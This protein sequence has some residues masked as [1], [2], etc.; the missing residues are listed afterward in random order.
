MKLVTAP[1]DYAQWP[2][3]VQ[4]LFSSQLPPERVSWED[5]CQLSLLSAGQASE[6][7]PSANAT[8]GAPSFS[9][10][11]PRRYWALAKLAFYHQSPSRLPLLYRLAWRLRND[12]SLLS[13]PLDSDVRDLGKLVKEVQRDAHK[14]RA[15]IRFREL[16]AAPNV[17]K[18]VAWHVPMHRVLRLVAPFFVDRMPHDVWS[19]LT[20]FESAHWDLRKLSYGGPGDGRQA[21]AFDAQEELWRSYYKSIFNPARVNTEAMLTEMPKKYWATMPETQDIAGMLREARGREQQM[22]QKVELKAGAKPWVPEERDLL[23]LRSAA[24]G[25][26]GCELYAAAT[27]TVFGEGPEDAKLM[28][29]G[30]QPGDQEDR[31]GRPFVGPAGQLLDRALVA[32]ELPRE[33]LYVT[34]AVKHFAFTPRGKRRLHRKP[35]AGEVKACKPWLHAEMERVKPQ[36]VV[37]LGA[38]AAQ[39]LF[40]SSFR[41]T[42]Q[43][44]AWLETALAPS[45]LATWHPSNLLRMDDPERRAQAWEEL[46]GD[47]RRA[48]SCAA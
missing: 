38:T 36:T 29:I 8:A 9:A 20:P 24:Q 37:C 42:Q 22:I 43:R 12:I 40:G 4:R 32:A 13:D 31:Q 25:C 46:V 11:L 14:A 6:Q 17:P 48:G 23:S 30:E 47:L 1:P 3:Q 34:N 21:P 45:C 39:T 7:V 33:Q 35:R 26:Q 10:K 44:G 16:E 2:E 5:A 28:L 41:L 27:Q 15:F 19:I 18:F